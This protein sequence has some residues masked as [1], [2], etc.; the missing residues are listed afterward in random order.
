MELPLVS[1][2][3]GAFT[4]I[5]DKRHQGA[6]PGMSTYVRMHA[7]S[8]HQTMQ[9]VC[10]PVVVMDNRVRN[11]DKLTFSAGVRAF[12]LLPYADIPKENV[13]YVVLF[14]VGVTSCIYVLRPN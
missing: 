1:C 8:L 11:M 4:L 6:F 14:H 9:Y 3:D 12:P 7:R 5:T 10:S 13:G 2:S